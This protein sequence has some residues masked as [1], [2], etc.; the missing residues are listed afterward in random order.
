MGLPARLGK[1]R[2]RVSPGAGGQPLGVL[3][4]PVGA[5]GGDGALV[6]GNGPA[7]GLVL[8]GAEG[9]AFVRHLQGVAHGELGGLVVESRFLSYRGV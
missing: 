7:A 1:T 8:R 3:T 2:C 9:Q 6:Q 5:Q 4:H